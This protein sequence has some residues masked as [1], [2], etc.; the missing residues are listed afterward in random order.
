MSSGAGP[1]A[2]DLAKNIDGH[3]LGEDQYG[4]GASYLAERINGWPPVVGVT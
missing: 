3:G 2:N 4:E 1:I